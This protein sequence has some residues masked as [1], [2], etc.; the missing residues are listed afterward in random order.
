VK[1]RAAVGQ[2]ATHTESTARTDPTSRGA[3]Q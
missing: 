2:E 1:K 3:A